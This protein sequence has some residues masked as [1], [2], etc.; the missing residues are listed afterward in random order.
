MLVGI[1]ANVF[2]R[3][4]KPKNILANADC[5]LKICDFGLARVAFNDAPTAI[6]WTVSFPDYFNIFELYS[7]FC[8][9]VDDL[10]ACKLKFGFQDY[11]ATR[12]YRAPELCGSFFSKVHR[13]LHFIIF[14]E[15][16]WSVC[17]G[18]LVSFLYVDRLWSHFVHRYD[19]FLL[20][21]RVRENC[22]GALFASH[23]LPYI[24][25]LELA[26]ANS[27]HILITLHKRH[28][29]LV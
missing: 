29:S 6:F 8:A 19:S 7:C 5:K 13:P 11:V 18:L 15:V 25:R 24:I 9:K 4:L 12:W 28:C 10:L 26:D 2:H 1:A 3:D 16:L 17:R 27:D 21:S 20:V 22:W 23:L 14:L